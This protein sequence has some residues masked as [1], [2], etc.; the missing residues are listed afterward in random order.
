MMKIYHISQSE[1]IDI[2]TK[3]DDRYVICPFCKETDFDLVGLKSHL[4]HGDCDIFNKT[5]EIARVF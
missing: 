2:H 5:E 3:E 1:N 4:L